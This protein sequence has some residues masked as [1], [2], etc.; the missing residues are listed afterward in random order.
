M[1]GGAILRFEY[2]RTRPPWSLGGQSISLEIV[3][4]LTSCGDVQPDPD[5]LFPGTPAQSWR[6]RK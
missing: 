1:R 2:D 4:L 3:S 5:A 6:V